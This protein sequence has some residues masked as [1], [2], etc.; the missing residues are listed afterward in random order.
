[1]LLA[2]EID[3]AVDGDEFKTD[4]CGSRMLSW[5]M[6]DGSLWVE[7]STNAKRAAATART[8]TTRPSRSHVL[9]MAQCIEELCAPMGTVDLVTRP[10]GDRSPRL[11]LLFRS[12]QAISVAGRRPVHGS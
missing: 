3:V 11:P 6:R 12:R 10:N 8:T 2:G 5:A 7:G 9:R 1:M 4:T